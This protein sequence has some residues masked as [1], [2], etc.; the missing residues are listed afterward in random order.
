MNRLGPLFIVF[1]LVV[2]SFA[3]GQHYQGY[4]NDRRVEA[5][6]P[7]PPPPAPPY[8]GRAT[9]AEPTRPLVPIIAA[10]ADPDGLG[11]AIAEPDPFQRAER[12]GDLLSRL[13]PRSVPQVRELLL[14]R[15]GEMN[16]IELQLLTRYWANHAPE[17]AAQWAATSSPIAYRAGSVVAAIE[18]WA[19][20]DAPA[21]AEM[22]QFLV[23]L[24]GV[25]LSE[26]ERAVARIWFETGQPG[27][28]EYMRGLGL[29]VH[30]QRALRAFFGAAVRRDGPEASGRW[31]EAISVEDKKFKIDAFR[32]LGA[33]L[34]K[35]NP[36]DGVA[37]CEAHCDGRFGGA[38]RMITAQQWALQDGRAAMEWVSRA[39]PGQ[40]RDVAVKG[41][42]RGWARHDLPGLRAWL[43]EI[44]P[45]GV[46]PW[47]QAGVPAVALDAPGLRTDAGDGLGARDRG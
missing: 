43:S 3:A 5:A 20:V 11:P 30:R 7:P 36:A 39:A 12:L 45:A 18:P 8:N 2:L 14:D 23:K 41:A 22:V 9:F 15:A 25:D 44:T 47:F 21:A 26:S 33:V 37:W 1:G 35:L 27:V 19:R 40:E 13:D 17:D 31:A 28:E 10:P 42:I 16:G 46:E 4:E 38:L 32:Q 29:T 24:P 6:K 34:T